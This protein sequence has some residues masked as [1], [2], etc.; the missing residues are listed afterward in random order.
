MTMRALLLLMIGAMPLMAAFPKPEQTIRLGYDQKAVELQF[1]ADSA[2]RKA[3]PLCECTTVSI[4][5][6]KLTA[7]VDVSGFM[8]SVTKY[9]D[10]TLA[11]GSTTRLTMR[12]DVPQAVKIDQR[13]LI[14]KVGSATTAKKLRI[15]LPKGSPVKQ[16]VD[17]AI[18]GD[19]FVYTPSVLKAGEEYEVTVSPR[20]TEKKLINRLIITTDSKDKRYAQYIIYLSIQP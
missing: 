6:N 15:S 12:F 13:S 8:Q 18:S 9:I 4:H 19:D 11:D 2:I 5:G 10:A 17:A 7:H 14:W 1:E 20:S 16:V 3:K